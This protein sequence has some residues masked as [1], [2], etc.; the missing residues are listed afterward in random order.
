VVLN[1]AGVIETASWKD[2]PDAILC[3]WQPGQEGG[4]PIVDVLSG[5]VNPSGKLAITFPVSYRDAPTSENFPG[6]PLEGGQQ[7]A[8]PGQ[9]PMSM[10]TPVPS[11]VVYREDIY[12]G[13]RY[14][15]TFDIPVS[16]EFG[17]GRSYTTFDYSDLMVDSPDFDGTLKAS[18]TVTN[19][20]KVAGK[21]IVQVYVSAPGKTLHKPAMELVAFGKTVL[22]APGENQIL[23]FGITTRDI[24]S[25]DEESSSWVAEAG[26]YTLKVGASSMMILETAAFHLPEALSAG[27]VSRALLPEQEIAPL[28]MN[29]P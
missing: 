19:L 7:G 26:D 28:Y 10:F 12:V 1:I 11:E 17:Y 14:Y 29:E 16:Y 5:K 24:A 22:L 6:E 21:E 8:A 15:N 27:T 2:V 20:G 18:V 9:S 13:Y 3:A 25:F 23:E 4:H